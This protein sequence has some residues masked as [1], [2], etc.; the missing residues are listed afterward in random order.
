M[1]QIR[2]LTANGRD[3]MIPLFWMHGEPAEL[4]HEE[5]DRIAECGIGAVCVESR[6]H[7]EYVGDAWWRDLDI[8]MNR[9][10][11]HNMKVYVF[12]D[13][14]YPTGYANGAVKN[15][16]PHL[17]RK[18]LTC[19]VMD[20][21]GPV[22]DRWVFRPIGGD[23]VLFRVIAIGRSG[24]RIDLSDG[25][26]GNRVYFSLD[27]DRY[28]LYFFVITPNAAGERADAYTNMLV[29]ESVRILIDTV[30]EPHY[31]R[32]K[33]DFG[34]TFAGFFSD[35]PSFINVFRYD[36]PLGRNDPLPWSDTFFD[37]YSTELGHEATLNL[38]D[39]FFNLEG[40]GISQYAYMN[41]VSRLYRENMSCQL[42][43]WCIERGVEY[44]G[45]V[46]EDNNA[47]AR[48][49]HGASHYFRAM[50]GQTFAGIDV[51]LHQLL[52]GL[53]DD[54]HG[55]TFAAEYAD[56]AFF[57]YCM[58]E[59]CVSAAAID[60]KKKN[61]SLCEIF[62]A[63]GWG[64]G[65]KLMKWL[66]DFM[67][68]RGINHFIPHAF[69]PKP[70][71]DLDC[72]PHF[73]LHGQNPQYRGFKQLC[74]YMERM[75]ALINGG[76]RQNRVAVLYHA[77]AE[78]YG[79]YMLTQYPMMHLKRAQ[80]NA[81]IM[82]IDMLLACDTADGKFSMALAEYE[83]L[84]IP[85]ME[86]APPPLEAAVRRLADAG[87]RIVFVDGK[88]NGAFGETETVALDELAAR[89]AQYKSIT[90]TSNEPYLRVYRYV[91]E[92]TTIVLLFNEHPTHAANT[93]VDFGCK[94]ESGH[95][96]A[97]ADT[98]FVSEI[99]DGKLDITLEPYEA[100][101]Y[102]F[103]KGVSEGAISKV[104]V[105]PCMKPLNIEMRQ[106]AYAEANGDDTTFCE[107]APPEDFSGIFRYEARFTAA[108]SQRAVLRLEEVYETVWGTLNGQELPTIISHPYEFD[109]SGMLK[110]GENVLVLDVANTLA[111][112]EQDY[113][114][115]CLTLEPSGLVGTVTVYYS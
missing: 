11:L 41:L 54:T 104:R 24:K 96:D 34:G 29:K 56:D 68:V 94:N 100:R 77:E 85:W 63:Y 38:P 86:N 50:E 28:R 99:N 110:E 32:Y 70:G 91:R 5:I 51:V 62:G 15:A 43:D 27:D 95:Y 30:Y 22:K 23:D 49:G 65:N 72:P 109:I 111:D 113:H 9:C 12:D 66:V 75:C 80:I 92:E 73:Y 18:Y 112:R 76:V 105:E 83:A 31:K 88:P 19:S 40:A 102:I 84:V 1:N 71:M 20:V 14:T 7:P 3:H 89:M 53:D 74:Y 115:H 36:A 55:W 108:S 61:R 13:S 10:R 103:G 106:C 57:T 2:N 21:V 8:V 25:I 6:P 59:M 52:P 37:Q 97:Y 4:I 67:L 42:G 98:L 17:R 64:E 69:N 48:L 93:T 45:H 78:W 47:H 101:T 87:V 107:G 44:I 82:P 79:K 58:A 114:S 90:T 39:L 46:I 81:D 33:E 35:E 26:K 16:P 60:A